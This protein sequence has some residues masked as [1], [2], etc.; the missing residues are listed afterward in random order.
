M[1][2]DSEEAFLELVDRYFPRMRR[3]DA[4]GR[5]DDCAVI[6]C[7][8]RL[9]I[10]SDLFLEGVHFS[11]AYFSP[12][13]VGYKSLAV[14]ISDIAAMAAEPEGFLLNLL[15]PAEVPDGFWPEYF[16]GLAEL[17]EEYGL[18]LAGGDLSRSG[19][20][21]MGITIWG[22]P[23]GFVPRGGGRT[24]D[25][26]F[27]L[28][29]PGLSAAGLD[30]LGRGRD[31][32]EFPEAVKAH[33]RPS[34]YVRQARQL[35]ACPGITALM[36]VSDGLAM[37]VPRILAPGT[38]AELRLGREDLHPEV[39]ACARLQGISAVELAFRGGEE[40]A[41]L[42]AIDPSFRGRLHDLAPEAQIVGEI[43]QGEGLSL[44]GAQ[45]QI[46]G[47]DHMRGG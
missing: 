3:G 9:C 41:L 35:G 25:L 1:R 38:G 20:L 46:Q 39:V 21:G 22:S 19:Q 34:L 24:G 17:A 10:S 8:E 28:G 6:P 13:D 42:G 18:Y 27:L 43:V 32:S 33:L 2:L 45:V 5:G 30:V 11:R 12:R 26:L 29:E 14:N 37:D 15:L 44:N 23:N 7:R 31:P 47:F 4:G 36:D 40:Y 16:L